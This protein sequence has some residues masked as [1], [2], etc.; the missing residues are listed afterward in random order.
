MTIAEWFVL[1]GFKLALLFGHCDC[2]SRDYEQK[3]RI[4]VAQEVQE[5]RLRSIGRVERWER[6]WE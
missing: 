6:R 3:A 1:L 5:Y 2:T 4:P